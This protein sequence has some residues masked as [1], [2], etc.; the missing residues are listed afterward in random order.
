MGASS[1]SGVEVIEDLVRILGRVGQGSENPPS[2]VGEKSF[3]FFFSSSAEPATAPSSS[4]WQ[5]QVT[6][7]QRSVRGDTE[8]WK[9]YPQL[10]LRARSEMRYLWCQL[11][12]AC[13][14]HRLYCVPLYDT[15]GAGAV[16]FIICHGEIS[17]AF[18]EEK[19]IPKLLKTFP[20]AS[21]FLKTLV[22][23]F[24]EG[25]LVSL[26]LA[27]FEMVRKFKPPLMKL[28]ESGNIDLCF[29]NQDEA[30]ELLRDE[31]NAD[32]VAALEFLAKYCKRAVVT[33]GHKE[34]IAKHGKEVRKSPQ[35]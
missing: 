5:V 23:G 22:A 29:A 16:E 15:L 18:V 14:A 31:H 3:F 7:L 17:I 27:S 12:W 6:N 8:S 33:L 21:K 1:C 35:L 19:K 34:C 20:N 13:N 24:E 2:S 11:P 30:T 10:W 25:L 26:D 28:L 4:Y 9:L 32:P